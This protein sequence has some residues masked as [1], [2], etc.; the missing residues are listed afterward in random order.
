MD[1]L[2]PNRMDAVPDSVERPRYDRYAAGKCALKAIQ[3]MALGI[4]AVASPV[5]MNREVIVDGDSGFLPEDEKAWVETLDR[6][7]TDDEL[8]RRVGVAGRRRI[9]T[10]YS[11]EVVGRRLVSILESV[12]RDGRR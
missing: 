2:H 6:L 5:G 3:Y 1:R 8:A 7:L 4:P 9:E 10:D 11:L 12:R